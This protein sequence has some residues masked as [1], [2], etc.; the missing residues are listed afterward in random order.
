M[1]AGRERE[2]ESESERR[3]LA[4]SVGGWRAIHLANLDVNG[5]SEVPAE[6]LLIISFKEGQDRVRVRI[7][8]CFC[9]CFRVNHQ[10]DGTGSGLRLGFCFDF[11]P[12]STVGGGW[13]SLLLARVISAGAVSKGQR[14]LSRFTHGCLTKKTKKWTE[15]LLSK[16]SLHPRNQLQGLVRCKFGHVTHQE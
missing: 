1:R 7:R 14:T 5:M 9:F 3:D 6:R 10:M 11:G 15:T 12:G 4:S 16:A 8:G 13:I 2:S